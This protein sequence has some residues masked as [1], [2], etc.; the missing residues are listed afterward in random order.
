MSTIDQSRLLQMRSSILNQNQAL[1]RAAG[2]AAAGGAAGAGAAPDFGSAIAS[3]LQQVNTQQ[4][5]ASD[6]SEAYERGD[7]HDIVSVMIER[8]KASLGFE[9]TLQVRNKLL[10]AYRDIMNMPV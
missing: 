5:K 8:Q 4:A 1:Q 10:S 7:T 2:G 3:A 9:T 6:L